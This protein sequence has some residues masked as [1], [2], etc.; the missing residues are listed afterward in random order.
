MDPV[1]ILSTNRSRQIFTSSG[2]PPGRNQLK[3]TQNPSGG[4]C[5]FP[6]QW[7]FPNTGRQTRVRLWVGA[8]AS[9]HFCLFLAPCSQAWLVVH[10]DG[11]LGY[12]EKQTHSWQKCIIRP[13]LFSGCLSVFCDTS[14]SMKSCPPL[15]PKLSLLILSPFNACHLSPR[16]FGSHFSAGANQFL[17]D[18]RRH[19]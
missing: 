3:R 9:P 4:A 5:R 19:Q 11:A 14:S 10:S 8:V 18:S 13:S 6:G 2:T 15:A 16:P 17:Q 12:P 7:G 1:T